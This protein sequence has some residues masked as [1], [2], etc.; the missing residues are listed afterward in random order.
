MNHPANTPL[1]SIALMLFVASAVALTAC[2]T[3]IQEEPPAAPAPLAR[4][5][6]AANSL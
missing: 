6:L 2:D 3:V 5:V 4:T 1:L